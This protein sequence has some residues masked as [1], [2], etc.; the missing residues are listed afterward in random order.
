M[1]QDAAVEGD[2]HRAYLDRDIV[3]I[4]VDRLRLGIHRAMAIPV[5]IVDAPHVPAAFLVDL[6]AV[7]VA[8]GNN[9]PGIVV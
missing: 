8:V 9:V 2:I 3:D 1:K 7:A 6:V 4:A 5:A